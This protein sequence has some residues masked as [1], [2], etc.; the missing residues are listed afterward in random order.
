LGAIIHLPQ[1]RQVEELMLKSALSS[2]SQAIPL[3][4]IAE[5]EKRDRTDIIPHGLDPTA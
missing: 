1:I 3:S 2:N 4:T 5:K